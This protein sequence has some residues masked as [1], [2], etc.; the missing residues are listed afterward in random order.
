MV[1]HA[2]CL[3]HLCL[4]CRQHPHNENVQTGENSFTN[5]ANNRKD[6]KSLQKY[7]K[8]LNC[9]L[10]T[11]QVVQHPKKTLKYDVKN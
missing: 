3:I 11:G 8:K 10:E 6:C 1:R 4:A 7:Y 9:N 5:P 2:L